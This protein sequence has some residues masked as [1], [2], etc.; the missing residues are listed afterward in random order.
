MSKGEP[1]GDF[2]FFANVLNWKFGIHTPNRRRSLS[3][4]I[5][6]NVQQP[7]IRNIIFEEETIILTIRHR[8]AVVAAFSNFEHCFKIV[9][10]DVSSISSQFQRSNF[11]VQ[12]Q[13]LGDVRRAPSTPGA[14]EVCGQ[15]A[16]HN[17]GENK[18]HFISS[19]T[20]TLSLRAAVAAIRESLKS[21][22]S[23][24]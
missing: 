13:C 14:L 16:R 17:S 20:G 10:N 15:L 11:A 6:I 4:Q 1:V 3:S 23:I 19:F 12:L 8:A 24:C 21:V 2:E 7:N 22:H 18:F 5:K 9:H